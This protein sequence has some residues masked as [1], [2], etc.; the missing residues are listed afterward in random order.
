MM[1]A[2]A[3]DEMRDAPGRT[4]SGGCHC[5]AV[6]FS[7]ELEDE[8]TVQ[9]C[10]CSMCN[11]LGFQHVIVPRSRFHLHSGEADITTY[12]FNTGVAKHT[13]CSRCGVKSFYTPR[14]NPDGISVNLRCLRERPPRVILE[15]FDGQHWEQHAAD[16]QHLSQE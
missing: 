1:P 6:S 16:L 12:T 10:N 8:I 15:P 5:G 14:S 13:F 3:G 7:V 11:M 2:D 9:E 4:Y